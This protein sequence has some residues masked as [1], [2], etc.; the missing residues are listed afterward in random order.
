MFVVLELSVSCGLGRGILLI[1]EL[2][3]EQLFLS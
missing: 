2:S 1:C 3:S